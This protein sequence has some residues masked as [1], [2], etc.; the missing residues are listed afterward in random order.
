MDNKEFDEIIT[1]LATSKLTEDQLK[2]LAHLAAN[3]SM[4]Q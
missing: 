4:Y 2:R 3:W 1:K